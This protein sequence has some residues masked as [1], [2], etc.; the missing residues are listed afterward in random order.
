MLTKSFEGVK[1]NDE[2]I[3]VKDDFWSPEE[4]E[5]SVEGVIV[6]VKEHQSYG[7]QWNIV[8]KKK[9]LDILTPYH[10]ALQRLMEKVSVG[11]YIKIIYKG[12]KPTNKGNPVEI[13]SLWLKPQKRDILEQR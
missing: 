2:W 5:D 12:S 13:Y 11:D 9:N 6:D 8:N 7:K 3:E 10:K 4:L 1:I